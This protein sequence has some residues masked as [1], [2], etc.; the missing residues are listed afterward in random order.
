MVSVAGGWASSPEN[1]SYQQPL[2]VHLISYLIPH[3]Q[4][5]VKSTV[6]QDIPVN[7]FMVYFAPVYTDLEDSGVFQ[8]K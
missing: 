4:F 1:L 2:T 5:K 6:S 8:S 3:F 7:M